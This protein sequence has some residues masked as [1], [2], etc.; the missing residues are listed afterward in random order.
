TRSKRDWSSDVCSSDLVWGEAWG[1]DHFMITK[2][3]TLKAMLR[4]CADLAPQDAE[5]AEGRVA[6][7]AGRLSPW[8][9]RA[10]E[11]RS[12]GFYE[13]FRSEEP[14]CRERGEIE[15]G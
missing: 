2:P 1:N 7:W 11:F 5:P 12:D 3:V 13:R 14:S 8:A 9:E 4:V 15:G 6:R 10:R